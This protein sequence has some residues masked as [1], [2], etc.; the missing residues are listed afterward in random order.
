MRV[1]KECNK[2]GEVKSLEDFYKAGT[3]D[4]RSGICKECAKKKSAEYRAKNPKPKKPRK[5]RK[6]GFRKLP[7]DIRK[8]SQCKDVKHKDFFYVDNH[9]ASGTSTYCKECV[10]ERDRERRERLGEDYYSAR[11]KWTEDNR[12]R[13]RKIDREWVEKNRDRRNLSASKR[14][15]R[16][17]S[18]PDTLTIEEQN[19]IISNFSGKC[20]ICENDFEHLD[21]FIP[22]ASGHG[23]TVKENMVPMCGKC[24]SSKGY[25]NPFEW[26]DMLDDFRRE[27]FDSLVIYLTKINGIMAVEDYEAHVNKCFN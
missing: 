26:A 13:I 3:K 10:K 9:R 17:A 2:C 25:K 27:R 7:E 16:K 24:N 1:I 6:Q 11:R 20:S 18:L 12:E 22:I 21:H 8:C 23:G 19:E 4:G 15:A 5:P 14:R